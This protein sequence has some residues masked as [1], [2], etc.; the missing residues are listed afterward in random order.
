[1]EIDIDESIEVA[2]AGYSW[3]TFV[4]AKLRELSTRLVSLR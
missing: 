4:T 2:D 1:M 3:K